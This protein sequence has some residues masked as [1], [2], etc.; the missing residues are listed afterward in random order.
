MGMGEGELGKDAGADDRCPAANKDHPAGLRWLATA[1]ILR[2]ASAQRD[3]HATSV[4]FNYAG[5]KEA[6]SI[7][8]PI[9]S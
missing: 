9:S 6:G 7:H 8:W 5:T 3:A 4:V 1:T 2:A